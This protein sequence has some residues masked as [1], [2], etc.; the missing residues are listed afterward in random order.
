MQQILEIL[1]KRIDKII[2]IIMNI[3]QLEKE[4]KNFE[5]DK[6]SKEYKDL[7]KQLENQQ[8]TKTEK[9]RRNIEYK[10]N[11]EKVLNF[12]NPAPW[13]EVKWLFSHYNE[14]YNCKRRPCKC[15]GKIR[16]MLEKLKKYYEE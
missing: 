15:S 5:G 1:K 12:P 3:K 2:N 14:V 9:L 13:L 10:A 4:L 6:R 8:V 16:S 11:R 7:K